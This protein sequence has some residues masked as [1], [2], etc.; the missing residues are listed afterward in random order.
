MAVTVVHN[1]VPLCENC[2]YAFHF[3]HVVPFGVL[4]KVDQV[5][6]ILLAG[7]GL[8]SESCVHFERFWIVLLD[9]HI[10]IWCMSNFLR[11]SNL[12]FVNI[13]SHVR[14]CVLVYPIVLV[15]LFLNKHIHANNSNFRSFARYN[16]L[17]GKSYRQV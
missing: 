3:N 2:H 5:V 12:Y 17:D 1:R 4:D 11:V 8:E 10:L 13:H 9:M 14:Y 6:G 16:N 7:K 15:D